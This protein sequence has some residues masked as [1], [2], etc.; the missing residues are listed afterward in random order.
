MTIEQSS[1]SSQHSSMYPFVIAAIAAVA[2]ILFGFDTGV[3]SGA[4]LFIKTQFA[5]SDS[6]VGMA[7]GSVLVGALL[8]AA[9]SSRC[10]DYWGRRNLLVITSIIFL[11]GTVFSAFATSVWMLAGFRLIVGFA[12]GIASYTAPLYISEI[13]PVQWRGA[14]VS[15]NQ[16]AITIGI[17]LSYVV[18][19]SYASSGNWR[20][21]LGWGVLPAAIL[22]I[23]MMFLPKSP[24][25]LFL[26]GEEDQARENLI[27]I[28]GRS[29]AAKEFSEMSGVQEE[30]KAWGVLRKEWMRPALVVV[31][32]L[33]FFQQW[34]GINTIIYYAP[35]IFQM[36]GFHGP[37]AAILATLGIGIVNV[38]ATIVAL[39]LIDRWGRRPLLIMGSIGMGISLGLFSILFTMHSAEGAMRVL[40]FLSLVGYIICFAMSLGPLMWVMI[41]EVLPLSV[42][43]VGSGLGVALSWAF[44]ALVAFM[45]PILLGL[46]HPAGTFLIFSLL[47]FACF[48]YVWFLIP[49]TKGV[50]L[51]KIESRL[52][53]GYKSRDLGC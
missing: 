40:A 49:E 44:N 41:P 33:A 2:G 28:H 39:P 3:I 4:I 51:E 24:R 13:A 11:I 10:S 1:A 27:R 47:S 21:M 31:I 25:W 6:L 5:L 53:A 26:K 19:V 18:D 30:K 20:M 43:G 23:G 12:I 8:G 32:G 7:V 45:F 34:T 9:L 50:S 15:L 38:L 36:T 29:A 17:V 14:L 22:F 48:V 37:T 16:L 52:R 42:R 46:L 35:T